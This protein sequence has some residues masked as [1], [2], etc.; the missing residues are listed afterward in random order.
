MW[1][2]VW[3]WAT[4]PVVWDCPCDP[5]T[6]R[7]PSPSPLQTQTENGPWVRAS[8]GKQSGWESGWLP[9][10]I[11]VERR[12]HPPSHFAQITG[13][14]LDTGPKQRQPCPSP[15][16]HP[17]LRICIWALISSVVNQQVSLTQRYLNHSLCLS[18]HPSL[19][20]Q[21][22]SSSHC[23]HNPEDTELAD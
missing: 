20:P 2:E 16:A 7:G 8:V 23:L 14:L 9:P 22:L 11:T 4:R 3:H 1:P 5:F 13:P 18:L 10:V 17:T 6:W 15:L 21:S 19:H 12:P